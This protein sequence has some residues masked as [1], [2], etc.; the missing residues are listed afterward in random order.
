MPLCVAMQDL[1]VEPTWGFE[2]AVTAAW[3]RYSGG[4]MG[5]GYRTTVLRTWG[6]VVGRDRAVASINR[7]IEDARSVTKA[8]ELLGMSTS[9]L[10]RLRRYFEGLPVREGFVGSQDESLSE[11]IDRAL[12]SG[13]GDSIEFK[14][15]MPGQARDLAKEMAAL[16]T[17]GGGM[18]LLGVTDHGEVVGFAES[19]ERVEGVVQLVN[20]T[21]RVR[22]ETH[23]RA[24]RTLCVVMV[25]A[26][27]DPV[28]YV[29]HRPYLRD[30]SISRPARPDEVV[31]LVRAQRTTGMSRSPLP[32]NAS[33]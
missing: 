19:R 15:G 7:F 6:N 9:T 32:S 25:A 24:G 10:R 21:P 8:A 20:P 30:G 11:A 23:E 28:Y 18:I 31:R 2:D 27:D 1:F 17:S 26:G 13:E 12:K 16:A 14:V 33:S 29:E 4:V 3:Q 22:V 5:M